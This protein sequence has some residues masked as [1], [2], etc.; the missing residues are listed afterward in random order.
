MDPSGASGQGRD[1]LPNALD[2]L[3]QDSQKRAKE[4]KSALSGPIDVI[5]NAAYDGGLPDAALETLVDILTQSNE[6]DQASIAKLIRHLYPARRVRDEAV[7]KVIGCLGQGKGKPAPQAQA[8]ML[9]WLI[10]VFDVLENR[11]I[12]SK[13]YGV[14]FGLLDMLSLR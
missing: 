14:L 3:K 5:C 12:V 4:R 6:L 10:M 11:A 13:F 7:V 9:K 8:A 1:A 2:D